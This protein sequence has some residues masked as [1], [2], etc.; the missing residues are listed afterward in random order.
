M[1]TRHFPASA[2]LFESGAQDIDDY[3]ANQPVLDLR[4]YLNG[5]LTACG[6]FFGLTA[7]LTRRLTVEMS[8]SWTENRGTL[9][10]R[11][12]Y[13]DGETGERRWNMAFADSRNFTAQAQDVEGT[14][15]GVQSGNAAVMRYRLRLARDK[16]TIIVGMEDWFYL[17]QDGTLINRA[18]MTK[19]GFKVG[20]IVACFTKGARGDTA[21]LQVNPE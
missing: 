18:R 5:P 7:R 17:M 4:D 19:F 11:F 3:A 14:A 2:L 6:V 21:A 1:K 13:D 9:D 16:G 10:E 12:R 15:T 8:A 20:E